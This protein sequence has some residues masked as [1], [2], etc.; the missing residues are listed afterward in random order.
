MAHG[1]GLPKKLQFLLAPVFGICFWALQGYLFGWLHV[2]WMIYPLLLLCIYLAWRWRQKLF[3]LAWRQK[4]PTIVWLVLVVGVVLQLVPIWGS[5]W[6]T[7]QGPTYYFVNI[8]DGIF[9]LSLSR[10]LVESVPPIQPGAVDLVVTNYHYLSNLVVAELSRVWLLPLNHVHFHF[11]PL[12]VATWMGLVLAALLRGWSNNTRTI[13][14]GLV[15]FYAAGELSWLIDLLLGSNAPDPFEVF[16]DHGVLQF[17]NPPQAFA[18]LLFFSVLILWHQFWYKRSWV[19]ALCIGVLTACLLG[20]KVY[21]GLAAGLGMV[22]VAGLSVLQKDW[23]ANHMPFLVMGVTTA[24]LGAVIYLP[25]N[26]AA[27]GLFFDFLTWPKLLLGVQKLNWNEWWLRLQVY[28]AAGNTRALIVWYSL[29]ASI[30]M[31][32]IYHIRLAGFLAAFPQ[33]RQRLLGQEVVFL[34]VPAAV[35][36]VIGTNFLQTSGGSNSFNFLVVAIAILNPVTAVLLGALPN[37]RLLHLC[38]AGVLFLTVV[39]TGFMQYFY[40]KNYAQGTNGFSITPGHEAALAYLADHPSPSD[41]LQTH[42]N[43]VLDKVTPYAYFFTGRRAYLGGVGIL[44]SHNQNI[45]ARK[46]AVEQLFALESTQSA[47]FA[48][49]LKISHLLLRKG[50]LLEDEFMKSA[51]ISATMSALP[52]WLRV[53]DN[54]EV[55]LLERVIPEGWIGRRARDSNPRDP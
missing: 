37:R 11:V 23:R 39:Q 19:I 6:R 48:Q 1:T 18:K 35:F 10:S 29:A 16:V 13:L 14:F 34:L 44:E 24:L 43:H 4:L 17:L 21:F 28:Q 15:L 46:A 38:V 8:Y 30:F 50:E 40:L 31:G 25:A 52:R 51:T 42:P 36:T 55:V 32:A 45:L 54:P 3:P 33:L 22:L 27:G 41:A 5:G 26:A 7:A 2:R 12:F 47:E 49:E 53:V 9:H 20:F